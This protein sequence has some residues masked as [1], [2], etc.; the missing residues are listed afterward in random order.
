MIEN[1]KV[2]KNLKKIIKSREKCSKKK[3]CSKGLKIKMEESPKGFHQLAL[4]DVSK[5]KLSCSVKGKGFFP[6][7]HQIEWVGHYWNGS[8]GR[9]RYN[10]YRGHSD[11]NRIE[12][13]N[14][15]TLRKLLLVPILKLGIVFILFRP[16]IYVCIFM[17]FCSKI[18]NA[19]IINFEAHYRGVQVNDERIF[20]ITFPRIFAAG[21]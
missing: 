20:V 14:I 7:I 5:P 6:E 11:H 19:K 17:C 8:Q 2:E 9:M 1:S 4:S 12:I 18:F 21:Q 16:Y 10:F 3:N 13:E 15:S